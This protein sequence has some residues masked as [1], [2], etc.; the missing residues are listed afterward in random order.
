MHALTSYLVSLISALSLVSG[1]HGN[2]PTGPA[3]APGG[4]RV[5][6]VGN[7]LT[8]SNNLPGMYVALARLAGNTTVEAAS[9]AFPDFALESAAPAKGMPSSL[10]AFQRV[11]M[12]AQQGRG[13]T[14]TVRQPIHGAGQIRPIASTIDFGPV[15]GR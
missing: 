1:C 9:V 15:A 2:A 6:F 5:L 10:V 13:D 11:G 12:R 3:F 4:T 7:S 14:T 8:Y